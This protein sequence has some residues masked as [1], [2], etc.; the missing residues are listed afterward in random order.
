MI[1][2]ADTYSKLLVKGKGSKKGESLRV[3]FFAD[4]NLKIIVI[5]HCGEHLQTFDTSSL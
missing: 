4:Y 3:H 2:S 1:K 5:A